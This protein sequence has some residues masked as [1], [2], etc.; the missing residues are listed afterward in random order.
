MAKSTV[1]LRKDAKAAGIAGYRTMTHTELE[2]A[3]AAGSKSSSSGSTR[4]AATPQRKSSAP[5]RKTSTRSVSKTSDTSTRKSSAPARKS[6]APT[7]KS[8]ATKASSGRT[9][10]P[11]KRASA[12]AKRQTTTAASPS[13]GGWQPGSRGRIPASAT[14]KAIAEHKRIMKDRVAEREMRKPVST[15][16]ATAAPKRNSKSNGQGRISLPSKARWNEPWSQHEGSVAEEIFL[17]L[18]SNKGDVV[19]TFNQLKSRALK[20][21]GK[22]RGDVTRTKEEALKWL[23]YRISRIKFDYLVGTGQHEPGTDRIEYGTG[24]RANGGTKGKTSKP[25]TSRKAAQ[26]PAAAKRGPGRPR[27]TPQATKRRTAAPR[28]S[29]GSTRTRGGRK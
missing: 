11:A 23:K 12:P 17:A 19:A 9:S 13:R 22:G 14:K 25:S 1:D 2:N 24:K 8:T 7:R 20:L 5:A 4:K 26:K 10:A 18:K 6:S 21:A 15:R 29:S 27:S 16:K 3:I 28:R